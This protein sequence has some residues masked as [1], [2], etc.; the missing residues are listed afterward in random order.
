M[1]V[2]GGSTSRQFAGVAFSPRWRLGCPLSHCSQL[3]IMFTDRWTR[4]CLREPHFAKFPVGFVRKFYAKFR[5]VGF[6]EF[7]V[8]L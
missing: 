1:G 7:D 6:Q 4:V 3:L 8:N 5:H 2:V